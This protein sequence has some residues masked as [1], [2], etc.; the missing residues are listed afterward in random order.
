MYN[1]EWH[2]LRIV[3]VVTAA[4]ILSFGLQVYACHCGDILHK[5]TDHSTDCPH[6]CCQNRVFDPVLKENGTQVEDNIRLFSKTKQN[7]NEC[8]A[9]DLIFNPCINDP[10]FSKPGDHS[11]F[12]IEYPNCSDISRGPPM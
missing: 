11:F 8:P 12:C 10:T 3:M 6:Y 4:T 1:T 7:N 5:E 9:G 2:L